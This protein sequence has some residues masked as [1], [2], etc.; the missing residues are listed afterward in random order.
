[1]IAALPFIRNSEV[2]LRQRKCKPRMNTD[3][4][5]WEEIEEIEGWATGARSGFAR[6]FGR[7]AGQ[8]EGTHENMPIGLSFTLTPALSPSAGERENLTTANRCCRR[9]RGLLSRCRVHLCDELHGGRI[10]LVSVSI[11]VHP[12]LNCI[13]LFLS[14]RLSEGMDQYA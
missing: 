1:M 8:G 3:K 2:G 11:R 9:S 5:G 4:H 12:W 10:C 6:T 13:F 14:L 7:G